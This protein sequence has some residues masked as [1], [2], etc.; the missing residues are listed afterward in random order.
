MSSGLETQ[1]LKARAAGKRGDTAGAAQLYRAILRQFPGNARA[2]AALASLHGAAEVA[3]AELAERYRQGAL[4]EVVERG[5]ALLADHPDALALLELVGAAH[6]GLRHLPEAEALFRRVTALRPDHVQF[7]YLLGNVY[8]EQGKLDEAVAAYRRA[9]ALAPELAEAHLNLGATLRRAGRLDEAIAACRRAIALRPDSAEARLNLGTALQQAGQLDEAADAYRAAIAIKPGLI[10]AHANLGA[11]LRAQGRP[12]EAIAIY[13]RALALKP[14]A[15]DLLFNLA[16]AYGERGQTA[17][18]IATHQHLL[19]LDPVHHGA[20]VNL[21]NLLLGAGQYDRAD[22]LFGRALAVCAD[23]AAAIVGRLHARAHMCRWDDA[24]QSAAPGL[25]DRASPFFM[26]AVEDDPA[27]QLR[28]ARLWAAQFAAGDGPPPAPAPD[29]RIRL[30]Y[31]SA[32]F[33]EHAAL[34]L[35]AGLLREHDRERFEISAYSY[36]PD[37][38][39]PARA[40]M[41]RHVDRFVD[42]RDMADQAVVDLARGHGLDIAVDLKGYTDQGRSRLFAW[43]LAP[44]QVNYLGYP[45]SMG[46]EFMDYLVADPALIPE[47]ER[48]HYSERLILLPHSYQPNDDR[49]PIA[50]RAPQRAELGLPETGFVFCSFN[51]SY[52]ITPREFDIWMRLLARV[53]GS[54]LWLFRANGWAEANLRRE[55]AARGVDPARLVFAGRLAQPEHLARQHCADLFLDSFACNAHTTASDALWGGLPVL[56]LAGRQ[57]AAR[58]GASL[59]A[60]IGLPEL[61]TTSE[62]EY[63]ALAVALA[64]DPSRLAALRARLGEARPTAPLFDSRRYARDLEAGFAIAHQRHRDGQPPADIR[65]GDAARQSTILGS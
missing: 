43:R 25:R 41:Q 15:E 40:A 37:S 1:L 18:A 46:A 63:E 13:R 34:H 22:E 49:R 7:H 42:I 51:N 65:I 62:A 52:K 9:I 21:A 4:A 59:L 2:R 60:A 32:D 23:D 8:R 56:T 20:L 29:R 17:N 11:A 35:M 53:H 61:V 10:M 57:F 28:R 50:P 54:V 45:G 26:I 14:D 36:G 31:F 30:G 24:G 48:S 16:N 33:H 38:D 27:H 44:V 39:G 47:G 6:A 55:A 5:E 58:V 3:A 64:T 12:A 19:S